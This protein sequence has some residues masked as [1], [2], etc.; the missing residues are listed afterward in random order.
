MRLSLKR[1]HVDRPVHV[2]LSSKGKTRKEV[3]T[4]AD[5]QCDACGSDHA[6]IRYQGFLFCRPCFSEACRDAAMKLAKRKHKEKLEGLLRD[7]G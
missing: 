2:T 7:K 1:L 3:K 6:N 5:N 4:M